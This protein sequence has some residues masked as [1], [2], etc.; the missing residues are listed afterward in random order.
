MCLCIKVVQT[1]ICSDTYLGP[2]QAPLME[3]FSENSLWHF[4]KESAKVAQSS[5]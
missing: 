1:Q 2:C 3:L 4:S 5:P